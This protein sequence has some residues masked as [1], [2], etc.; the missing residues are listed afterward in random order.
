[1]V[2]V[3]E[4]APVLFVRFALIFASSQDP[5]LLLDGGAASLKQTARFAGS[6]R[7]FVGLFVCS[8]HSTLGVLG[9]SGLQDFCLMSKHW[10]LAPKKACIF[11]WVLTFT[12]R[13]CTSCVR[14]TKVEDQHPQIHMFVAHIVRL[15]TYVQP[16]M[17]TLITKADRQCAV[18]IQVLAISDRSIFTC[19]F[20]GDTH[21][22]I[23]G[24]KPE[25]TCCQR[26]VRSGQSQHTCSLGQTMGASAAWG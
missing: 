25:H 13:V 17:A 14:V 8:R 2:A 11:F 5:L 7:S 21:V 1:L 12:L 26:I 15:F 6:F 3:A 4:V 9:Y 24:R 19:L 10:T 23:P 22:S 16:T 20:L 18:V